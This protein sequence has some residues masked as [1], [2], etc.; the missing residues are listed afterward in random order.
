MEYINNKNCLEPGLI[1][2]FVCSIGACTGSQDIIEN[3]AAANFQPYVQSTT[4]HT[5]LALTWAMD[6]L[7]INEAWAC[8]Y[9]AK[10]S[11]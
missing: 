4:T 3:I 7:L 6:M 1:F 8:D 9:W 11:L 5:E 10:K 2:I